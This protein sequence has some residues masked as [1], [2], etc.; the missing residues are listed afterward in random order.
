MKNITHR[1][2]A[3][4]RQLLQS[5]Y[6]FLF[7]WNLSACPGPAD[8]PIPPLDPEKADRKN[9]DHVAKITPVKSSG[10][11]TVTR[12]SL[13]TLYQ[14]TQGNA[15]LI[16]DVRPTIFYKISHIPGAVSFPKD[17]FEKDINKHEP[18]IKDAVKKQIPVVIY[19]T[20]LACPDALA[21]ADQISQRGHNVSVLQGGYEAWKCATD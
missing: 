13:G 16:F 19:C 10:T 17:R 4:R 14:L 12:M 18:L 1:K 15:A 20:D 8:K 6:L 3:K 11:G 5:V 21:V 9:L 7:C 2:H